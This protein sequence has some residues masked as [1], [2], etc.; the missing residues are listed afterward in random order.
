[1]SDDIIPTEA[2]PSIASQAPQE[3][4]IQTI[5]PYEGNPRKIPQDA[6]DKVAES[7]RMF[8]WQQPIV[9]DRHGVIVV[10]HTRRLAA[11]QLGMTTVPI[12]TMNLPDDKVREY[13]L[14]DNKTSEM[15]GWDYDALVIELREFD[16]GILDTFFDDIKLEIGRVESATAPT[17]EEIDWAANSVNTVN[18]A[19]PEALHTTKVVCP[20]CFHTFE[21]RTR[22]LPGMNNNRIAE[23][24]AGGGAE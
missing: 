24:N 4:D 17:Q 6:I 20:S 8:G 12:I 3:V 16:Q 7:L 5:F 10:G 14:I 21:V 9:V 22:S 19:Q 11:L 15:S 1:M 13:R 2:L 23:M 18:E